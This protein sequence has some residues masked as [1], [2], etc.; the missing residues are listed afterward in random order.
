MRSS[1]AAPTSSALCWWPK[2]ALRTAPST[3]KPSTVSIGKIPLGAGWEPE[4]WEMVCGEEQEL[5]DM[6]I[7]IRIHLI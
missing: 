4:K 7:L 1:S 6:L 5:C 3:P 2:S